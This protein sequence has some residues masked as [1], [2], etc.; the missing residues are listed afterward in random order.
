MEIK[1]FRGL[2]NTTSAE[3]LEPGY[4]S[5]AQNV[6]I[7]DTYKVLSRLGTVARQAGA[8]HSLWADEGQAFLVN[9]TNDL[10]RVNLDYS[11]TTLT[12]LSSA[13]RVSYNRQGNTVYLSN[14][15]DKLRVAPDGVR[16]WG[17]PPPT[18][19]GS[20]AAG[21]GSLPAGRYQYALTYLRASG[22]ESGA[23]PVRTF[24]LAAPG[25]LV[26]SELPSSPDPEVAA[27]VIYL[28]TANGTELF[29]A[30]T[31]VASAASFTFLGGSQDLTARLE[32]AFDTPPSPGHI[33]EC[34]AGVMYVVRGGVIQYSY[35]WQ[36]E[37]FHLTRFLQLPGRVTMFAAVNDGIF[38]STAERTWFLAGRDPAALVAKELFAH[39][40]IEGTVAKTELG[41]IKSQGEARE[42][43]SGG[44]AV[45][46]TT[47]HGVCVG[48]DGGAALNLTERD[49]SFPTAQRGAGI[50]RQVR[51]YTQ[52][53]AVLEGSG[54]AANAYS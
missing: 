19:P 10:C 35:P 34:H 16:L 54:L 1:K 23:S 48:G 31:V 14:G 43:E 36:H 7:D 53:L 3:R 28:S 30:A 21:A 27:K 25:G 40:A 44:T 8:F 11:L 22:T 15:V 5:L 39:G 13:A 29:R 37:R 50:V 6:D 24:D 9:S 32:G 18:S 51:G 2:K 4:L 41:K 52:Y 12:R 20:V 49:F 47:P 17:S 42:G 46:W 45:M 38:A 33:V 26:F